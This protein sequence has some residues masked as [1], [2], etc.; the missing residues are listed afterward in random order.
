LRLFKKKNSSRLPT[1]HPD[2]ITASN[3]V[4]ST[5][6]NKRARSP[7]IPDAPQSKKRKTAAQPDSRS[8]APHNTRNQN[9]V[10][11]THRNAPKYYFLEKYPGYQLDAHPDRL[12]DDAFP[13]DDSNNDKAAW[14]C[15]HSHAWGRYINSS[16][17][18]S[19]SGCGKAKPDECEKAP[20]GI[21][22]TLPGTGF[23]IDIHHE[24]E[25]WSPGNPPT[26]K[27]RHDN[28]KANKLYHELIHAKVDK[29]IALEHIRVP[30]AFGTADETSEAN[31]KAAQNQRRTPQEDQQSN[32]RSSRRQLRSTTSAHGAQAHGDIEMSENTTANDAN[33]DTS[34]NPNNGD[35]ARDGADAEVKA[36]GPNLDSSNDDNGDDENEADPGAIISQGVDDGE[37]QVGDSQ[38]E[39]SLLED[40]GL[41][42]KNAMD[43]HPLMQVPNE[44]LRELQQRLRSLD[45]DAEKAYSAIDAAREKEFT[46]LQDGAIITSEQI[47][48][49]IQRSDKKLE[50][51][52][53]KVREERARIEELMVHWRSFK[54]RCQVMIVYENKFIANSQACVREIYDMTQAPTRT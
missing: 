36:N 54:A 12:P 23:F 42:D 46:G 24:G 50:L 27:I 38:A 3:M 31:A 8:N 39:E 2:P 40:E 49:A 20:Y 41:L 16:D 22:K 45:K 15:S 5:R 9:L 6:A 51:A 4:S 33:A 18:R 19:C 7:D 1:I 52:R 34:D 11:Y 48:S 26:T 44:K 10:P 37:V 30:F 28:S 35:D 32:G 53:K 47:E 29:N 25:P 43:D 13:L 14:I 21:V 17:K